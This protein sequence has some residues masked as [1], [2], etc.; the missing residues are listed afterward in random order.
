MMTAELA[1]WLVWI[2][3]LGGFGVGLS[4]GYRVGSRKGGPAWVRGG[5]HGVRSVAQ[6]MRS[7]PGFGAAAESCEA[8]AR[9]IEARGGR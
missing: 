3:G 1:G 7:T 4:I 2:A 9:D 5:A 8:A 6:A